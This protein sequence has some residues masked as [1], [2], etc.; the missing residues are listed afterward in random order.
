MCIFNQYIVFNQ[1][2]TKLCLTE[3][4]T[5]ET[6]TADMCSMQIVLLRHD[7]F[8]GMWNSLSAR[9]MKPASYGQMVRLQTS[10][11]NLVYVESKISSLWGILKYC[12][13][14]CLCTEANN[15]SLWPLRLAIWTG[16]WMLRGKYECEW[17]LK[18]PLSADAFCRQGQIPS[19]CSENDPPWKLPAIRW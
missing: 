9:D 7:F 12:T 19:L 18:G 5:A 3:T 16:V 4:Q 10:H 2:I 17:S 6:Q 13:W 15:S 11:Y 8:C 1:H 14:H